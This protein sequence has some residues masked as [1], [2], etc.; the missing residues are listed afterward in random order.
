MEKITLKKN[1]LMKPKVHHHYEDG[2]HVEDHVFEKVS[3]VSK[4]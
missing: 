2:P 3:R 1:P 4:K